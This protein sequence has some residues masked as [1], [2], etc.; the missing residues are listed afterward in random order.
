MNAVLKSFIPAFDESLRVHGL[1]LDR[2]P[3]EILQINV[4]KRCNQACHHCH[5]DAGPKRA[6]MMKE[7]TAAHKWRDAVACSRKKAGPEGPANV[8]HHV[9]QTASEGNS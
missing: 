8:C 6:E 2:V 9:R 5:V 7:R 4:G 1:N 3:L